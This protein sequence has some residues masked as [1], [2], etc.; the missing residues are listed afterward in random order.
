MATSNSSSSYKISMISCFRITNSLGTLSACRGYHWW[1][2]YQM[3]CH[4]VTWITILTASTT[5]SFLYV[6]WPLSQCHIFSFCCYDST[7][8][9]VTN[10][11]ISQYMLGWAA[12]KTQPLWKFI[13]HIVITQGPKLTIVSLDSYFHN[14][15]RKKG[16]WCAISWS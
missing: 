2:Y 12:V 14:C 1:Q 8:C 9:L 15:C 5:V 7:P 11:W 6:T 10:F 3:L 4:Y 16:R 13:S